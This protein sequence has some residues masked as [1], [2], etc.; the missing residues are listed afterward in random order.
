MYEEQVYKKLYLFKEAPRT[1]NFTI[2]NFTQN[3]P[4][5]IEKNKTETT[6]S[7]ASK[8]IF[9]QN[10]SQTEEKHMNYNN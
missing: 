2:T 1:R 4:L 10:S 6:R 3:W 5:Y 7:T 8:S 9:R